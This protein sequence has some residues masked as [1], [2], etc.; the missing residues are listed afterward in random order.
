M[1]AV[2]VLIAAHYV[3]G[4]M[5]ASF[6]TA[7]LVALA[8]AVVN[9]ILKPILIILTLPI[10][11]LTLG[12]FT[13]VI[14]GLLLWLVSTFVKGFEVAGFVPAFLGALIIS[15]VSFLGHKLLSAAEKHND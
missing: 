8:L 10:T 6:Y 9:V 5:V 11:I 7:L 15:V 14:N 4:I 1:T 2:A 12:L 3:P 13:L